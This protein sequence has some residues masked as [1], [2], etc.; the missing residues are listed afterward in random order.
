M[1]EMRADV[2]VRRLIERV[3]LR[4]HRL[5]A[6]TPETAERLPEPLPP[7]RARRRLVAARAA[8]LGSRLRPAPHRRRRRGRARPP[9]MP[10]PPAA[11][12]VVLA[13]PEQVKG[14]E[15]DHV[16]LL[17][18]RRGAL[19]ARASA[20]GTGCRGACSRAG[21]QQPGEDAH[22]AAGLVLAYLSMTRAR[23][24]LGDVVARA[25]RRRRR[26]LRRRSTTRPATRW[27][28]RR[29]STRRSSSGR[30]RACT[31]PTGC[32]ATRCSRRHGGPGRRS[33]R[34]AS[35]RPRT[36]TQ[37]V[38]RYL[39]LIKLAALIQRP[40]TEP[41]AETIA[42]LNELLGRVASPEQ[43]AALEA[44]AL[45]EYVVGEERE[46]DRPA[47]AGRR[48]A[49]AVAR[50]VHPPARA[51]AWRSRPRTSTSTGPARSSTSSRASSRFR[52]SRR[53]TSASGS[54]STRSSSAS[55]PRRCARTRSATASRR[56]GSEAPGSLDRL[57]FL[58]EAGWRRT[59]FGS[60][61]DE[62][63]YR[64]RAV[65]ALAR[66]HERDEAPRLAGRCGS[67]AASP[68]RSAT[69]SSAAASTASTAE[70]DGGYE[71]IDYKTGE[72]RTGRG[73]D[74]V[75]L[76]LY[77]LAARDAWEIEAD[78]GSYWYVLGDERVADRRRR[79]TTPS[80]SSGPCSR[81][82][83]A[84]RTRTSSRARRTR[85]AAGATTG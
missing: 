54:S 70:P 6:A 40:G 28:P 78:T 74:D 77:R 60:S 1:E 30:P 14:L 2:F 53:S 46:R 59:G 27:G 50:A 65:A 33:R 73:C 63:Q 24:A 64:D 32:S 55:T 62:L 43:R 15:F 26:S 16:Y 10:R 34:C 82:A 47:R 83:P 36:S 48:P 57:L 61:D 72:P 42:A 13:E 29:R 75:Q 35:T 18:L 41:A 45:D 3:G 56:P 20:E 84:S 58:F 76:A 79:P 19:P 11:G 67:S 21:P 31:R 81:S 80:G 39:E 7:R 8:R 4:R 52:R 5:F 38:A 12:S 85:S 23:R 25:D 69:I 71:L 68:S 44:S 49:R 51:T 66:Y 22:R 9:T 17:G 37:A